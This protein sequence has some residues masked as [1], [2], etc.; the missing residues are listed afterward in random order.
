MKIMNIEKLDVFIERIKR[1]ENRR[2][3]V[4]KREEKRDRI[5]KAKFGEKEDLQKVKRNH[6]TYL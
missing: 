6:L 3:F 2:G 1:V 4:D 5:W